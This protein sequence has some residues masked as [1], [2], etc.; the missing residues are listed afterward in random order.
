MRRGGRNGLPCKRCETLT[1]IA[2]LPSVNQAH[3]YGAGFAATYALEDLEPNLERC[4]MDAA[5]LLEQLGRK[6]AV[7]HVSAGS[8]S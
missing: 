4:M 8:T 6:I 1:F 5:A 2:S 7:E 3:L